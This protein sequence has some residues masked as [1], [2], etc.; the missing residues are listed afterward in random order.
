MLYRRYQK[1]VN[2]FVE[3]LNKL[4]NLTCNICNASYITDF[5]LVEYCPDCIEDLQDE[6]N[7]E[8]RNLE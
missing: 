6:L 5:E 8:G 4:K 2:N 3:D 1:I 7:R